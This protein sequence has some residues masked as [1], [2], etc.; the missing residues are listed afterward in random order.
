MPIKPENRARYPKEWPAIRAAILE[1]AQHRCEWPGCGLPNYSV[2]Y[3]TKPKRGAPVWMPMPGAEMAYHTGQGQ[4]VS[5]TAPK[6]FKEAY[7]LA[8]EAD[9]DGFP[10][11]IVIVLTVAH[12]NHQPEDC[13]PENLAA[14][15]QQHHLAYDADHHRTTAYMTRKARANTMELALNHD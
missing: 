3:W 10:K 15:C 7:K 14:W 8:A 9:C 11:Y 13:A 1:R 12:L 5:V 6:T 2:G 4:K